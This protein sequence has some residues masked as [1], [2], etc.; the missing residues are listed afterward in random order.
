VSVFALMLLIA[1]TVSLNDIL[2]LLNFQ[3]LKE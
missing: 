1:F 3:F 2:W